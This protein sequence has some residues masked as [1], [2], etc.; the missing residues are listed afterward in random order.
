MEENQSKNSGELEDHEK[1]A[2]PAKT[3][4]DKY[5]FKNLDIL[6]KKVNN[7][8]TFLVNSSILLKFLLSGNFYT[9]SSKHS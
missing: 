8:G 6:T 2:E 3:E 5:V 4:Q 7:T 1:D 9:K